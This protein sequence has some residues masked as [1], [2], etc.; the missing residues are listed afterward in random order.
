MK[1]DKRDWIN[2][3]IYAIAILIVVIVL[4]GK[5]N[6]FG[7]SVDWGSQHFSFAEYFRALFY[8]TKDL[9]PDFALNIGSGQNIYN[10]AYY[11]LLSPIFLPSYLLPFIAMSTYIQIIMVILLLISVTLFYKWLK[12][13]NFSMN[14]CFVSSFLFL[15]ATPLFFHSH[16]HIMFVNYMP[17]LILGLIGVDKYFKDNKKWLIIASIF[18]M[19][20]TSFYY[21]I[22]GIITLGIYFLYKYLKDN[23]KIELKKITVAI[24]EFLIPILIAILMACIIILPTFYVIMSGR[25]ETSVSISLWDLIIPKI[26]A[27]YVLYE[28]Y[29][30]GLTAIVFV[31]LINLFKEKKENIFLGIIMA[32]FIILP[33]FNYIMNATMYIDAKI[34]IP[35]LPLYVL[36]IA[37]FTEEF[38]ADKVNLKL[39][40]PIFLTVLLLSIF[41]SNKYFEYVMIDGAVTVIILLFYKK[42]KRKILYIIPLIILA[43]GITIGISKIDVLIKNETINGSQYASMRNTIEKIIESDDDFYRISNTQNIGLNTNNTYSNINYY[44]STLYS[45]TYNMNYNLFYFDTINNAIQSRNRV[46]TSSTK[47]VLFL[48]LN[49]NKY[50]VGGNE[51]LLGYDLI[52]AQNLIYKTNNSL[53]IAYANSNLMSENDF[54]ELLEVERGEALLKNIVVDKNIDSEFT[55]NIKKI[56]LDIKN[57]SYD[58]VTLTKEKDHYLLDAKSSAKINVEL[59]EALTNKVLYIRFKVLESQPCELGDTEINI[60]GVNNKLTCSEWKYHNGNYEF[61]Y[62][63]PYDNLSMLN[64]KLRKGI[65]K[66]QDI[67]TYILDYKEIENV[68]ESVDKLVID[69]KKT[70]GDKIVGS[71]NVTKDG[72]FTASIPYEKG[73]IAK[74][75]G[76]T[77]AVE[78]VNTAFIGFPI[79]A[80]EHNIEIEYK[81]PLKDVG[82][83]MAVI[84]LTGYGLIIY[85]DNKKSKNNKNK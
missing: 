1:F 81:A 13:N 31:G 85:F 28:A 46:I 51:K 83:I 72:Y 16:R 8:E 57:I 23:E 24:L 84:G 9:F 62:V 10:F 54:N 76:K 3:G 7:S 34:L 44:F 58:N 38:F 29:G 68:N 4:V 15:C 75:D 21:S 30:V 27:K 36:A 64:L 52:D 11:G 42:W 80:G 77:I 60:N 71:I 66:I 59:K 22:S 37:I 40:I 47:N 67:D 41:E 14:V 12:N 5:E 50:Y 32:L 55:S 45:S 74:V 6:A 17:F 35:Q 33:I 39:I 25:G 49:A 26:N 69:S 82:L 78:K 48:M 2:I 20:M 61:D 65:Y 43:F 70:K 53:P 79:S 63:I 18:L 19:I 73:F 56:D